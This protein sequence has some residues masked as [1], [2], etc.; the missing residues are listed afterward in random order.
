MQG[1]VR[2]EFDYGY[3]KVNSAYIDS[4]KMKI[5]LEGTVAFNGSDGISVCDEKKTSAA[6]PDEINWMNDEN[7]A[8]SAACSFNI[9]NVRYD[10]NAVYFVN[11]NGNEVPIVLAPAQ[12]ITENINYY[13]DA[14]I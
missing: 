14:D 12:K 6:Y 11:V 5:T 2:A 7:G 4:G 1:S 3:I 13:E 9:K 10:E 8:W